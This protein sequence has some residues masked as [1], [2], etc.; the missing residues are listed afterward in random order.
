[1]IEE[2]KIK[3]TVALDISDYQKL[4]ENNSFRLDAVNRVKDELKELKRELQN[5]LV[6]FAIPYYGDPWDAGCIWL[7]KDE[8]MEKVINGYKLTDQKK[9]KRVEKDISEKSYIDLLIWKWREDRRRKYE[10]QNRFRK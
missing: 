10:N 6:R 2:D 4:V 8:A 7:S 9:E 1:M 3:G 5:G